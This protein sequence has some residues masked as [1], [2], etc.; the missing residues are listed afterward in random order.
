MDKEQLLELPIPSLDSTLDR[1]QKWSSVYLKKDE[2]YELNQNIKN[3]KESA[4]KELQNLLQERKDKTS[5]DNWIADWWLDSYLTGRGPTTVECNFCLQIDFKNREESHSDFL[6]KIIFSFAKVK[7]NYLEGHFDTVKN[8]FGK[9]LCR[10]QLE[11]LRGAS[12]VSREGKDHYHIGENPNFITILFKNNLYKIN[13]DNNSE[14]DYKNAVNFILEKTTDKSFS[15]STLSFDKSGIHLEEKSTLRENNP[16]FFETLENSLINIS[17]IDKEFVSEDEK[18]N[19]LLYLKGENSY[20]YKPL[21]FIY[22]LNSKEFYNNSEHTF[23]DGLTNV[24]IINAAKENYENYSEV[25]HIKDCN[26]QLITE[27]LTEENKFTLYEIKKNY[28]ENI[29]K[30][31]FTSH[32]VSL[33]GSSVKGFSKDAIIQFLIQYASKKTFNKYKG[34]YEAVDMKEFFRGRTECVRPVSF[35]LIA[36]TEALIAGKTDEIPSLYKIAETEHKKRIKDCKKGAGID[37]HFFGLKKLMT[38]L[39]GSKLETAEEFFSSKAYNSVSE[40]FISTT[41]LGYYEHIGRPLFTPVIENGLGISYEF[42]PQGI[43]MYISYFEGNEE[44]IDKFKLHFQEGFNLFK[45][46][47]F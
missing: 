42:A 39:E 11:I 40:S 41:S 30:Y 45:K 16:V 22:N 24:E 6:N 1:Y 28:M 29:S 3:F 14:A 15:L 34:T 31:K 9:P 35:E 5:P 2:I 19:Y 32:N 18:L 26:Y 7:D 8:Y 43:R 23:Q 4:G 20:M 13:I 33:D 17:L 44:I 37:R 46:I 36:L 47:L 27:H 21:N 12:R 38:G 10:K 25:S